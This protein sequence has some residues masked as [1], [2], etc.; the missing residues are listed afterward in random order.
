MLKKVS[1]NDVSSYQSY[2]I[3]RLDQRQSSMPDNEQYKLTNVK[4]DALSN[5][6]KHLDVPLCFQVADLVSHTH[7]KFPFQQ[8]SPNLT[9]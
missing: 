5:K 7:A 4:E 2:T 6:F 8:V 1:A 3:R 9:C